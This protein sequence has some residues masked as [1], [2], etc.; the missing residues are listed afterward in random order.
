MTRGT[1]QHWSEEGK[2]K[3]REGKKE[4]GRRWQRYKGEKGQRKK[5]WEGGMKKTGRLPTHSNAKARFIS[6]GKVRRNGDSGGRRAVHVV[7]DIDGIDRIKPV[8][9]A[10]VAA[11]LG[12]KGQRGGR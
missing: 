8:S 2:R 9:K 1:E 11:A 5:G 3:A 4:G 6:G 12:S 7:R 10:K